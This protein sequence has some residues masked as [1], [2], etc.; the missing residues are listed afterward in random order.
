MDIRILG[1]TLL[2]FL[3]GSTVASAGV[4]PLQAPEID[5]TSVASGLTLLLG[6]LVVL[7]GRRSVKLDNA[8]D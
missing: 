5:P 7:R 6:T 8:A 4:V 2:S 1:L 3:A